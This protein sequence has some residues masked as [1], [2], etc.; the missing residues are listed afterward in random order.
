MPSPPSFPHPASAVSALRAFFILPLTARTIGAAPPVAGRS[1]P[2][3]HVEFRI[4]ETRGSDSLWMFE[5]EYSRSGA[6]A[7]F[8]IAFKPIPASAQ[9]ISFQKLALIARPGS[10]ATTLLRALADIH[11]GTVSQKATRRLPRLDVVAGF[12]GQALGHD[13]RRPTVAGEF[14]SKPAG[15]WLVFK[16]F[17]DTPDGATTEQIGE[18]AELYLALDRAGGRGMFVVKD[19][20]Y[21]P[22][23]NRVLASVL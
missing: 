18:P 5:A 14:S 10:N 8:A 12:L 9:E 11:G 1:L 3:G 16:L 2:D 4:I 20:E 23:L 7:R 6:A 21:W 19:P 22:E 15:P 13:T 17:L